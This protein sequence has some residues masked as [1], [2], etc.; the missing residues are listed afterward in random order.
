MP[1]KTTA[2]KTTA[3]SRGAPKGNKPVPAAKGDKPARQPKKLN[4]CRCGCGKMV[5]GTF[6][7]GH[8]ARA[9]GM[10]LRGE[11]DESV[12]ADQPGL[13]S[14]LTYA[15]RQAEAKATAKAA[16][17]ATAAEAKASKAE[18]TPEPSEDDTE[19]T[20]KVRRKPSRVSG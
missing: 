2:R 7:Q 13:M 12:I 11:L 3:P 17:E 15:R 18:A 5:K 4:E 19:P 16:R 9:Y 8:D 10:V 20:P 6:A 1:T 14:K